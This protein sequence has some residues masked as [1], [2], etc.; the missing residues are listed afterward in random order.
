MSFSL[1]PFYTFIL[2]SSVSAKEGEGNDEEGL[3][4]RSKR[5][6]LTRFSPSRAFLS[7]ALPTLPDHQ[8]AR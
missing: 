4:T 6:R 2:K 3:W 8:K 5:S 7:Q 1:S